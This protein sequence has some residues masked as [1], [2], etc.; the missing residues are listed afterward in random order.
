MWGVAFTTFVLLTA[1]AEMVVNLYFVVWVKPYVCKLYINLHCS[2]CMRRPLPPSLFIKFQNFKTQHQF[3]LV[4]AMATDETE[5]VT[6]QVEENEN[7]QC[8]V[9]PGIVVCMQQICN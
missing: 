4:A 1:G 6:P 7:A 5:A 2:K 3:L 8:S 9:T